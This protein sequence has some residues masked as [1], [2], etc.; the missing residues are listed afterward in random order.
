[1]LKNSRVLKKAVRIPCESCGTFWNTRREGQGRIWKGLL[2][3]STG[4][5]EGKQLYSCYRIFICP[6]LSFP[7]KRA[8]QTTGG[9]VRWPCGGR[10][11]ILMVPRLHL[12]E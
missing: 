4:F 1:M 2:S 11:S 7:R 5:L 8:R 9:P 12:R 3:T 6:R 10:E